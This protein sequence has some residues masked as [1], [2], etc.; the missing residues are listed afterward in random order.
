MAT[1]SCISPT[2]SKSFATKVVDKL[3]DE[4]LEKFGITDDTRREDAIKAIQTLVEFYVGAE[5]DFEKREQMLQNEDDFIS[6][7]VNHFTVSPVSEDELEEAGKQYRTF[8]NYL[9]Q[10]DMGRISTFEFDESQQKEAQQLQA[11]LG[12]LD[13]VITS[14]ETKYKNG[15]IK[16]ISF[17]LREPVETD[18]ETAQQKTMQAINTIQAI[19]S[20][21]VK[22]E[23]DS[24]GQ[25]TGRSYYTYNGKTILVESVSHDVHG[26]EEYDG[27]VLASHIG[28]HVDSVGRL[29]FD[30]ES[31]L[32]KDGKLV[33]DEELQEIINDDLRGIFTVKGLK[34]LINDFLTLEGQL[35]EKWGND[36]Q[37]FSEDLKLFAKQPDSNVWIHGKPDLLVIDGKGVVHVLD[38][39]TS[40][41]LW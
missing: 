9:N 1:P 19:P 39:K 30:K 35:K 26:D 8:E 37:I 36:I 6:D 5:T 34:N 14:F 24:S 4:Q 7:L 16:S 29:V 21:Y 18:V 40:A 17:I 33:S 12:Q 27:P 11:I 28:T 32:W 22:P 41:R 20:K 15:K 25:R 3:S 10:W 38:F 13:K 23:K 31:K 2:V